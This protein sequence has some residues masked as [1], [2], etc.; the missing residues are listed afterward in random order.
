MNVIL[1][2][3]RIRLRQLVCN[4]A[5]SIYQNARD[6]EI[7][8]YTHVPYPY[9]VETARDFIRLARRLERRGRAVVF[10]IE[11][12]E[13]GKIIGIM[14]YFRI[15]RINRS[16]ELGYWLGK[17][18]WRKGFTLEA[19]NLIIG[20]MFREQKLVRITARVWRPNIASAR[21]LEKAGFRFEAGLRKGAFY[22]RRWLDIL[23]Y[24]IL[25]EE[26]AG[27]RKS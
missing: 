2:G 16:A 27:Q 20:W 7:G 9:R 25:R 1:E 18:H 4:D 15:D 19:L 11:E 5:E 21:L 14:N 17:K 3:K 24:A 13:T 23:C 12:L 26:Y 22:R 8:R 6:R 10:G